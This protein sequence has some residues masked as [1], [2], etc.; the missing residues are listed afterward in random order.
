MICK[1]LSGTAYLLVKESLDVI[2][3][4]SLFQ[5]NYLYYVFTE[6]L[7]LIQNKSIFYLETHQYEM[8]ILL[9]ESAMFTAWK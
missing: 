5:L 7:F 6:T 4:L 3:L 8:L 9:N 1:F 2:S